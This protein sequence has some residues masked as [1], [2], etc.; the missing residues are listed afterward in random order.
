METKADVQFVY[1][2]MRYNL[3]T[4]NE[5]KYILDK[6]NPRWLMFIPFLFWLIPHNAYKIA[7]KSSIDK[8]LNPSKSDVKVGRGSGLAIGLSIII[9]NLLQP[10]MHYFD[11]GISKVFGTSIVILITILILLLRYYIGTQN[12]VKLDNQLNSVQM[13]STSIYVRV[14]SFKYLILFLFYYIFVLSFVIGCALFFI[15]SGNSI[16]LLGYTFVTFI[17]LMGNIFAVV[18]GKVK[19]KLTDN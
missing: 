2:K 17:L 11:I 5:D 6:D 15:E 3:L 12:K 8:V 14:K 7:D 16:V 9:T 4:I 1:K 18:P 13:S 10:I 19:V